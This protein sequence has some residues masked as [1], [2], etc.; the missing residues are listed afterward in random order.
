MERG[1]YANHAWKWDKTRANLQI[2]EYFRGE[3]YVIFMLQT[4]FS[5]IITRELNLTE[6]SLCV[7]RIIH[8]VI[9]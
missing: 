4:M 5:Y 7:Y 2:Y 1:G 8:R 6:Y 9:H 3:K